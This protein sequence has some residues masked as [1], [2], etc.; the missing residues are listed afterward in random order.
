MTREEALKVI[1]LN[2][3]GLNGS[4]KMAVATLVSEWADLAAY[5]RGRLEDVRGASADN[6]HFG[7]DNMTNYALMTELIDILERIKL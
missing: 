6:E 2:K 3:Q 4:M 1:E 5:V 7:F